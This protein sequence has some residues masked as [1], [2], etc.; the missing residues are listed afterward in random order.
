MSSAANAP[1]PAGQ[2]V[3]DAILASATLSVNMR[4]SGAT[5]GCTGAGLSPVCHG[6]ASPLLH[7][8]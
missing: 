8:D 7:A 3:A 5:N 4:S 6:G 2:S 1:T